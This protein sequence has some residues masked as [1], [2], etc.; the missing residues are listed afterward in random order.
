MPWAQGILSSNIAH[1]ENP[2][3][4]VA[5]R[6]TKPAASFRSSVVI[7][8]PFPAVS[9]AATAWRAV[10]VGAP[11]T[12]VAKVRGRCTLV[13]VAARLLAEVEGWVGADELPPLSALLGL[14]SPAGGWGEPG[15]LSSALPGCLS[16]AGG[17]GAL[18]ATALIG[19]ARIVATVSCAVWLAIVYATGSSSRLRA[20]S[21]LETTAILEKLRVAATAAP[22]ELRV[23]EV[24]A[25]AA[26]EELR[27]A[28]T[29]ALDELRETEEAATAALEELRVAA[30]AAPEELRVTEAEAT[31][32]FEELRVATTAALDELRETELAATAT[33]EEL[34]DTRLAIAAGL[35]ELRV[36]E[37]DATAAFEELEATTAVAFEELWVTVLATAAEVEEPR[38]A[39]AVVADAE[40]AKEDCELA[41]GTGRRGLEDETTAADPGVD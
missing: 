21:K 31:A 27:V 23:T 30:T 24:A 8:A 36:A 37:L 4:N 5:G 16:P 9:L 6:V 26:F 29:A 39:A 17:L 1:P 13:E 32:S 38:T 10:L 7:A 3:I 34:R 35:E 22:E 11:D 40:R 12:L 25:T 2:A 33:L 14:S 20:S 41:A 15:L 28:A 18:C 19:I